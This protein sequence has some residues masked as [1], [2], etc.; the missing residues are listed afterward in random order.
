VGAERALASKQVQSR[1]V[2]FVLKNAAAIEA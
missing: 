1:F 2:G